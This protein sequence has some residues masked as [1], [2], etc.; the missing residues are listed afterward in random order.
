MIRLSSHPLES[1]KSSDCS[2]SGT[3]D[4]R[5]CV[6]ASLYVQLSGPVR[7]SGTCSVLSHDKK[8]PS[9]N[10]N[11]N[12]RVRSYQK[13]IASLC[14]SSSVIIGKQFVVF[15]MTRKSQA[16]EARTELERGCTLFYEDNFVRSRVLFLLKIKE[17][18]Q[19]QQQN[20]S[21]TKEKE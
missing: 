9:C 15:C 10:C 2:Y 5:S 17:R 12:S 4:C 14:C 6:I 19:F 1:V 3:V 16:S 13:N 21:R 11:E 20:L 7:S 8:L 18:Y